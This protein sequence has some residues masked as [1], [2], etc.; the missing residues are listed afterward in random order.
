MSFDNLGLRPEI[1][2]GVKFQGYIEPTPIQEQAIPIIIEG[3]DILASHF[4]TVFVQ[5]SH[6]E[7]SV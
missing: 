6:A 4:Q 7:S 2:T 1:L 3:R 5:S